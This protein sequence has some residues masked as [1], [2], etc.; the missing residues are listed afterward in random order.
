MFPIDR[1]AHIDTIRERKPVDLRITA[2]RDGLIALGNIDTLS[3]AI[4]VQTK[5]RHGEI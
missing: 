3:M 5:V 2:R 1:V 4:K